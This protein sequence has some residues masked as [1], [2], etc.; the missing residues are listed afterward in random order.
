MEGKEQT[1]PLEYWHVAL[2]EVGSMKCVAVSQ[3]ALVTREIASETRTARLYYLSR[4][5][6]EDDEKNYQVSQGDG[7]I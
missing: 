4:I 1:S 7:Y 6:F 2:L 5:Y 3:L